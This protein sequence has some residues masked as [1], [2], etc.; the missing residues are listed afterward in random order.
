M[1][2]SIP[3][4]AGPMR[5]H[6]IICRALRP[7]QDLRTVF[8]WKKNLSFPAVFTGK[9]NERTVISLAGTMY[10]SLNILQPNPQMAQKRCNCL[11]M[12]KPRYTT[13][14]EWNTVRRG[15]MSDSPGYSTLTD[16][17]L[18][19]FSSRRWGLSCLL[20][21]VIAWTKTGK[22]WKSLMQCLWRMDRKTMDFLSPMRAEKTDK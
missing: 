4:V 22:K 16:R 19:A 10:E 17:N 2:P 1:S 3:T 11:Q 21:G 5:C 18:P 7:R 13:E 9:L 20:H 14:T 8:K 12:R 15:K 6:L